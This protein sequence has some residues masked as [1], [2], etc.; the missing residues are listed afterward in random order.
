MFE[1]NTAFN[2]AVARDVQT[3]VGFAFPR[4]RRVLIAI[5]LICF[6]EQYQPTSV[7]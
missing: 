4:N 3:L 5:I 2:P 6:I 1:I 7:F